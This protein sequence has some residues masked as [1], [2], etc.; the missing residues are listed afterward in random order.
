MNEVSGGSAGERATE[1]HVF[2]LCVWVISG[3][4][5]FFFFLFTKANSEG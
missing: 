5:F 2:V 4:N 1:L 3:D